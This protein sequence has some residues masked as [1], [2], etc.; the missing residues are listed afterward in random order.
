ML[1][2]KRILSIE[3]KHIDDTDPDTS[4]L[5]KYSDQPSRRLQHRQETL[6]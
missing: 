5:G 2:Q 6:Y 1:Q 4:Y 3:V